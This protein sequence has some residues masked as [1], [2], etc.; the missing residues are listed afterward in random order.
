[1]KPV[2]ERVTRRKLLKDVAMSGAIMVAMPRSYLSGFVPNQAMPAGMEA[3]DWLRF[4]YDLQNTRFNS[5]EDV[6]VRNNVE[7]LKVKWTFES[8]APIQTTPTVVGDT[9]Y[10]GTLSGHQY[11]LESSTGKVKWKYF[12]GYNRDPDAPDQGVRSSSQYD[13]GRLYFANGLAQ[14]HC[15]DA[16]SGKQLWQTQL[17]DDPMRNRAQILCSVAVHRDKVYVGTSSA[18]AQAVCLDAGTGAVRW[19]FYVVPDRTRDGGGSIWT[20]PAVDEAA[21]IVYFDT[22][23][24]K[25]FMPPDPMLFTESMIAFD[26]DTGEMLWYDQLR[27]ADPFDLDYSC[28]PMI[29][30]AIHPVRKYETRPSVA[31]GNKS[32]VYCF[33][34]YTGA[35]YWKAMLTAPST[36]GGPVVNSTAVAYNRVFVVSNGGGVRGRT[37]ISVAAALHAYTGD[38]T[39]WVANSAPIDGPVAVAGQVFYQGLQDGTLEAMDANSGEQLWTYQLPGPIRSGMTIANGSLYTSTGESGDWHM[40]TAVKGKTYGLYAFSLDGQ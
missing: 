11:A 17:D 12:A 29:F 34:R 33:N 5:K 21:N 13:K 28:H 1:M 18:H 19:R 27:A 3:G 15:L 6:L 24:V 31:A 40:D 2:S 26:A 22:G 23:S 25:S 38:I 7:R 35:S 4:G 8:D 37:G 9:L 36:H 14:V 30:D 10:F 32:G 39:W 16:D 20:S